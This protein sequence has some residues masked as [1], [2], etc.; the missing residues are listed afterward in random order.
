MHSLDGYV[1]EI[2]VKTR[3]KQVNIVVLGVG[4]DVREKK[5]LLERNLK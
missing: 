4:S 1:K 2:T 5:L 3:L